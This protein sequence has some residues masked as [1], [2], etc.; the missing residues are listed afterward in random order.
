MEKIKF[1]AIKKLF[2]SARSLP[3]G[4]TDLNKGKEKAL[5]YMRAHPIE[6]KARSQGFGPILFP[7]NFKHMVSIIIIVALLFGGGGAVVASQND[8]PGDILYP[9]KLLSENVREALTFSVK[10]QAKLDAELAN[11]RAEELKYVTVEK[12]AKELVAETA[13]RLQEQLEELQDDLDELSAADR[14]NIML[15][16]SPLIASTSVQ[17]QLKIELEDDDE[18]EKEDDEIEVKAGVKLKVETE[19]ENEVETEIE[20]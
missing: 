18:I 2:Q 5:N 16:T 7:L 4:G 3:V 6:A 11:E 20:N 13:E 8:M 15:Q 1:S 12:K 17:T 9:V 10:S 19:I 14:A